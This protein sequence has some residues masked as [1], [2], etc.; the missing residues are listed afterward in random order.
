MK[1]GTVTVTVAL[2]VLPLP[3]ALAPMTEY[4]VVTVGDTVPAEAVAANPVL[5]QA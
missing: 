4:V 2:A 5:V 1:A 3:A